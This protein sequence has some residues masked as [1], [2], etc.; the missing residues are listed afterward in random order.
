MPISK[1]DNK[2]LNGGTIM[3][4]TAVLILVA[5]WLAAP[6][7]AYPSVYHAAPKAVAKRIMQ[8]GINPA[9]FHSQARF[10]KKLYAAQRPSTALAEKGRKHVLIKMETSK[11]LNKNTWDLRRPSPQLLRR[12][13]DKT[14]LRGTV[15]RG[16]IGP[17]LGQ[18]IGKAANTKGKAIKYRSVKSGGSN[19]AVPG[20][21]LAKHPRALYGKTIH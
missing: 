5:S 19:I 4:F 18:Q 14:D 1:Y 15:K 9:K 3:A 13:V 2:P 17:K 10:G 12:Y 21:M 20:S 6:P 16:V 11:Y 8:N 7:I